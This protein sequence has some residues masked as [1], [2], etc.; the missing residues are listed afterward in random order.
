MVLQITIDIFSGRPNPVLEISGKQAREI[1]ERVRPAKPFSRSTMPAPEFRLGYRGLIIQQK[2]STS[3]GLP[4]MF[5]VAGGAIY[6]PK[7][8]HTIADP[9]FE[10]FF[11]GP[12]GPAGK[13]KIVRDFPRM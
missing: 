5:R 1:L 6:G 10:R 13:I 11:A 12:K 2:R 3:R 9:E 4:S 7:L 8:A